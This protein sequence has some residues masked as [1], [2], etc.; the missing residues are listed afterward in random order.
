[1]ISDEM[2]I[3]LLTTKRMTEHADNLKPYQSVLGLSGPNDISSNIKFPKTI[4]STLS[5][6]LA[7]QE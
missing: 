1:M 6:W 7:D 5:N 2:N 3:Y 4:V